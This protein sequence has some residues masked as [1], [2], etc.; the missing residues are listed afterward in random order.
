MQQ[1]LARR[2]AALICAVTVA[3]VNAD[4][5][6]AY[7]DGSGTRLLARADLGNPQNITHALCPGN[8]LRPAKFV[9]RQSGNPELDRR[10]RFGGQL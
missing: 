8:D 3:V 6:F 2:A 7:A 10:A 1:T 9:G 4:T 5:G